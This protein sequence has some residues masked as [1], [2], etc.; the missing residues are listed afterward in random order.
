MRTTVET[1]RTTDEALPE[2]RGVRLLRVL[3]TVQ[4]ETKAP[5][6]GRSTSAS[7]RSFSR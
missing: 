6:T 1:A 7:S 3:Q 4:G 5:G 2:S